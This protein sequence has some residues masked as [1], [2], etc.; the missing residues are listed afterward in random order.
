MRTIRGMQS[1]SAIDFPGA[2]NAVRLLVACQTVNK[3]GGEEGAKMIFRGGELG[4]G[5]I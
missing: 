1:T 4:V 3:F 5:G 2:V